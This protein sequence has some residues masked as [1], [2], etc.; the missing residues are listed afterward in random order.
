MA[1]EEHLE[2]LK[3]GVV[4]WNQWRRQHPDIRPELRGSDLHGMYLR[5]T[6]LRGANLRGA[7]LSAAYLHGA[8][9]QGAYLFRANLFTTDLRGAR[10]SRADLREAY[11]LRA[12]LRRADLREAL[13][14]RADL[15]RVDFGETYL[16]GADLREVN[17][18]GAYLSKAYLSGVD[19]SKAHAGYTVF[20]DVD[21]SVVKGL[22]TIHHYGPSTIGIDTVYRSGNKIPEAFLR[23]AGVPDTFIA[24]VASLTGEAIQYY[25]CFISYSTKDEAF[26]QRLHADLRDSGVRCWFAPKDMKIG[27]D[28]W[29]RID[30]TIRVYDKL[31][32]VLSKNSIGS[33]WVKDEVETAFEEERRRDQTILFPVMLDYA[34]MGTDK[35]W[36]AKIR[37]RHIGDF[38][39]WKDHDSYQQAFD[40]LLR[41]LKASEA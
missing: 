14:F 12:D 3:Q 7:Y 8:Y 5:G 6:D 2:I 37:R 36:A 9:L 25:S 30:Q 22:E 31:L 26:A 19:L 21:L 40:R 1:N 18:Q 16:L 27:D 15:R 38:T 35:P 32:V 33:S 20:A 17:L 34:V 10:L 4:V 39:H 24:Y 41:D 29:A 28:I 13:L 23:G 11:L